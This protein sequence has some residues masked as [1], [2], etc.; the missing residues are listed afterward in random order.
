MQNLVTTQASLPQSVKKIWLKPEVEIIATESGTV[1]NGPEG[2]NT[3]FP[4]SGFKY[5]TS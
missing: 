2:L 1:P 3:I 5:H 4:G